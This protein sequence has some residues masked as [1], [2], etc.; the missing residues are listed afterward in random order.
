LAVYPDKTPESLTINESQENYKTGWIKLYRSVQKNWLWKKPLSKFE[1]WIDIILNANHSAMKVNFGNNIY[2]CKRGEKMWSMDTWGER[3]G[4]NKSKVRRFLKLLKDDSMIELKSNRY[5][6]HL[7]ICNYESYQDVRIS[8][9]SQM[10]LKRISDES[11]MT[12]IKELKNDKELKKGDTPVLNI[13]TLFIKTLGRNPNMPEQ[14]ETV[15]LIEKFNYDL[16]EK[17]FTDGAY[18]GC[19]KVKTLISRINDKCI[20][21][22]F[23]EDNQEPKKSYKSNAMAEIFP[24]L[25]QE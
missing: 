9:E 21:I 6:T 18:D 1:A 10:N 8:N 23:S 2:I 12:P 15:K 11:Q 25:R 19:K 22:P 16:V 3:W 13:H 20:Y 7:I 4:W 24:H 5:T 17:A 14:T